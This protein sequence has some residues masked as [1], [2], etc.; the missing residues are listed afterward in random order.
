MANDA[1]DHMKTKNLK[2]FKFNS[3]MIK[4]SY[5][6]APE[7][8]KKKGH[9]SNW[10]HTYPNFPT[11]ND[12]RKREALDNSSENRSKKKKKRKT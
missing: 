9:F 7:L 12:T 3:N 1:F 10:R 5:G 4:Q 8:K 11:T 2:H 6:G